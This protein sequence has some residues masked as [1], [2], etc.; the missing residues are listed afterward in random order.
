[1][2]CLK[3]TGNMLLNVFMTVL[4]IMCKSKKGFLNCQLFSKIFIFL[5]FHKSCQGLSDIYQDMKIEIFGNEFLLEQTQP[6]QEIMADVRIVPVSLDE[7]QADC[8]RL[9][10][11]YNQSVLTD[12][13]FAMLQRYYSDTYHPEVFYTYDDDE[14]V[15]FLVKGK[16]TLR[17][18]ITAYE[19][20]SGKRFDIPDDENF[21]NQH[22]VCLMIAVDEKHRGRGIFNRL[23]SMMH[24]PYY[25]HLNTVFSPMDVWHKQGVKPVFKLDDVN[26]VGLC[27]EQT[28]HLNEMV[29]P[30]SMYKRLK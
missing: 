12:A 8:R 4:I 26:Y 17:K 9:N 29:L 6:I 3:T 24:K 28:N 25:V 7:Y 30:M 21:D 11:I 10:R 27:G 16:T 19:Q 5:C 13:H 14:L 15:G 22:E 23:I 1:L 2:G 18:D 20:Q